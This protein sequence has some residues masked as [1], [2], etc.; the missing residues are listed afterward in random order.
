MRHIQM[1]TRADI[2]RPEIRDYIRSAI[3]EAADDP[4]PGEKRPRL[5]GVVTTVKVRMAKKNR[6]SRNL[7][8][9]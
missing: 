9:G 1:K 6:S 8:I 3:A 4:V 5:R 2:A 7:V